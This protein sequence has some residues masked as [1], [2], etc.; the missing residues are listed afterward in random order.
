MLQ[1]AS[2]LVVVRVV[3]LVRVFRIF[4]LSR[5]SSG[6]KVWTLHHGLGILLV[7]PR[8][9]GKLYKSR[10]PSSPPCASSFCW[11][12]SCSVSDDQHGSSPSFKLLVGAAVFYAEKDEPD[13]KF[14][15]IPLSLW[16]A[17]VTM[18]TLGYGDVVPVTVAGRFVG[19]I[20]AVTG[21]LTISLPVPIFAQNFQ[22]E[23]MAEQKRRQKAE[24]QARRPSF[25]EVCFGSS[26]ASTDIGIFQSDEPD[27]YSAVRRGG[28]QR[29]QG[30]T[31]SLTDLIIN[32]NSS[33][34]VA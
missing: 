14:R 29:E 27:W 1:S 5:H 18:T 8:S 22:E 26:Y 4:K 19:A 23:Y 31:V 17:I 7:C 16:W 6:L 10:R 15:S 12:S 9:L 33:A 25:A 20:T 32:L 34:T 30:G 3:R 28:I 24:R 2:S 13:T 11:V 21:V